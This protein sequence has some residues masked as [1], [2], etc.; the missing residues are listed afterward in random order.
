MSRFS[1]LAK[2][3]NAKFIAAFVLCGQC[4][5]GYELLQAFQAVVSHPTYESVV[6]NSL[7]FPLAL[8]HR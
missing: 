2:D 6:Y 1:F 4:V 5:D 8:F 3:M 7:T